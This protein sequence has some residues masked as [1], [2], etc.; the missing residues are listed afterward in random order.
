MRYVVYG[1]GAIGGAIGGSLH[2]AG[3]DV[4]LIARGRQLEA[5]RK[6]GLILQ[7]PDRQMHAAITTVDSPRAI[8]ITPEDVV[9]LAMKSQDT[10]A[11]LQELG[12]VADRDVAVVCAQNGVENERLALRR[13]ARVYGMFVYVTAQHLEPGF[14][15]VF[16]APTRGVLDLGRVPQGTDE[17][18]RAI[19]SDLK[20]AGFASRLADQI[21]RWKYAKL[22]SNLGNAV[23]AVLGPDVPGGEFVRGA[24]SEALACYAAAGIDCASVS[25]VSKR[26]A[27]NE[28]L[29]VVNG[30]ARRG[31]S[32]WQSL[33]R[34][35]ESIETDYLNGEI[36]LLGRLHGV[37]TPVNA[38]L[39]TLAARMVREGAPAGSVDRLEVKQ[40]IARVSA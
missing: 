12:E 33:A 29:R 37:R 8:D 35:S 21:M 31:G 40:E 36:V 20:A 27:R 19:S 1:A 23:E 32:S 39:C 4:V 11:A 25:E 34:S 38:A 18:A 10:A 5:L 2:H 24:R 17:R 26:A 9:L 3:R 13:F 28:Q 15:Q 7:T 6:G 30:Q 16:S 14:V 22:L